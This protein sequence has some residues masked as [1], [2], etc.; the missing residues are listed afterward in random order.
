MFFLLQWKV[1]LQFG[2]DFAIIADQRAHFI[3]CSIEVEREIN[4]FYCSTK[5]SSQ[6]YIFFRTIR[7]SRSTSAVSDGDSSSMYLS[8]TDES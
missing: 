7:I 2:Q 3:E 8:R 5:D 1:H 4:V 6:L